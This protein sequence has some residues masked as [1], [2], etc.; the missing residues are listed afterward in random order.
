MVNL[1]KSKYKEWLEPDNLL[2]LEAWARDG[3]TLEQ[4][5]SN[6]GI[7]VS[8]LC[9]WKNKYVEISEAIKKN[10]E[11]VDIEVEN[12]LLKNAKGYYYVEQVMSTK[13]EVIYENGKRLKEISEPVAFEITRYKAP[14]S[15]AQFF[16]LKNR[17]PNDWRDKKEIDNTN[18]NKINDNIITIADLINNPKPNRALPDDEV[19]NE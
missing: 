7:V 2:R 19:T 1:A 15:I 6:M 5:A 13:R 16:W 14:E 18:N 10:K 4:L 12:A 3:L 8:T 17:K 11:L 9:E